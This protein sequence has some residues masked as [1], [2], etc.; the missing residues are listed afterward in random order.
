M[1]PLK[2]LKVLLM[3]ERCERIDRELWLVPLVRR[4]IAEARKE[5]RDKRNKPSVVQPW[6]VGLA[7][8]LPREVRVRLVCASSGGGTAFDATLSKKS[9]PANL[10]KKS[11]CRKWE[12][13]SG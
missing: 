2:R 6:T 1:W 12:A 8:R 13:P 9:A 5:K 7:Q 11:C 10:Q 3:R 4:K